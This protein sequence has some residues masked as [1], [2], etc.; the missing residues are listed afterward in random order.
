M[1]LLY[2]GGLLPWSAMSALAHLMGLALYVL[3]PFRRRVAAINIALCFPE[4]SKREQHALVRAIFVSH[5]MGLL[6]TAFAWWGSDARLQGRVE[7]NGFEALRAHQAT[8]QGAIVIG[9]HFTTLDLAGRLFL[10]QAD[11]DVVYRPQKYPVYDFLMR[12]NRERL[13]KHAIERSDTR[14]LI[15]NIKHG[16]TVWYAPDQDYGKKN[17]VFAPFFGVPA[18]TLTATAKLAKI[19]GA[20]VYFCTHFRLPGNRY[21]IN[22]EGPLQHFPSGDDLADASAINRIVETAVRRHPEQYM[23]LHKRFKSR[24]EGEASLYP[25]R[26]RKRKRTRDLRK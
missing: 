23:W 14:T 9:C 5:A 4:L 7:A 6:E 16:R 10:S 12:R 26:A 1:G 3:A 22:I 20:P 17:A 24:P 2:L 19:T 25:K 15:R 8:G 13:F 21:Q 18:A 11:T